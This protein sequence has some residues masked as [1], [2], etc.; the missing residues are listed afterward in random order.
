MN[1]LTGISGLHP[2][3]LSCELNQH[4]NACQRTSHLG[5]PETCFTRGRCLQNQCHFRYLMRAEGTLHEGLDRTGF[6][7]IYVRNC[8]SL[9]YVH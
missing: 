7:D 4:L 5:F 8:A 2:L 6:Y 1:G 3:Y 9:I